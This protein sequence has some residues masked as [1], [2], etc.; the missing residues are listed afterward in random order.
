MTADRATATVS[1][2]TANCSSSGRSYSF[3][4]GTGAF[5]PALPAARSICRSALQWVVG[6]WPSRTA[7][8]SFPPAAGSFGTP[9]SG[10]SS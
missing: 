5:H 9:H 3:S 10:V 1:P 6:P 8:T 7:T 2:D 4:C